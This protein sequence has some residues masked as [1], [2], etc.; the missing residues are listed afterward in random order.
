M[1]R[2]RLLLCTA[3][4]TLPL[5]SQSV[6]FNMI[7]MS[8][9]FRPS[10]DFNGDGREDG[11]LFTQNP[12]AFH[13]EVSTGTGTYTE[14]SSYALPNNEGEQVYA[15][16]DFNKDGKLD[17]AIVTSAKKL[18]VY[19]GTGDGKFEAPVT[20]SLPFLPSGIAPADVNHDGK[21]DLILVNG[22]NSATTLVTYF[23]NGSG[24]FSAGPSSDFGGNYDLLGV[25]DFDGD[26]KAD[27][28]T[29]NC[30]PGG[31]ILYV[32]YGDGAGHFGS[33]TSVG[34]E[35]GGF[36]V[37]DL[38]GD[39]KSDI[40]AANTGYINTPDQPFLTVFYGTAARTL[41]AADITTTQC[42]QGQPAVADFNGDGIPDIVF[43]EHACQANSYSPP[44]TPTEIAFIAG[45]GNRTFGHEQTLFNSTYNQVPG[46]G[47]NVLRGNNSD[48]KP[49]FMF[50]QLDTTRTVTET[51]L[52]V[53]STSGAFSGCKPPNS[54]TG[55]R[56]CSPLS[57]AT[58]A[59]PV[60]FSFGASWQVP[61]RKTEVWVDGVK[62]FQSFKAFSDYGMLDASVSLPAGTHAITLI[63]AGWDNSLQSKKYSI[64]VH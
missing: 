55:F 59:S 61:V 50:S 40:V 48:A 29:A 60:K 64:T 44:D 54:A 24:G 41:L 39:G 13:A 45:L 38:D 62:K 1:S 19:R 37:A 52:M 16:A 28:A 4:F 6:S 53:N 23:G 49:D 2:L 32:Y 14:L 20:T 43:S 33:P 42:T 36:T 30:G 15:V 51:Y 18:Y 26:G 9:N 12:S 56:I 17:V 5:F 22:T 63:S 27:V 31:C 47:L 34:S 58:V 35:Q 11:I 57:G 46:M 3:L 7:R 25:G 10:G 8:Q 21:M